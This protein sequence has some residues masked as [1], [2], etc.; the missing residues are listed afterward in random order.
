AEVPVALLAGAQHRQG[1]FGIRNSEF[2][3]REGQL[4]ADDRSDAGGTRRFVEPRRA[5][6]AVAIEERERGI[7]K[8]GGAIHPRFRK[9]RA[10]KKAEGGG[11]V[12]FDIGG[13]GENAEKSPQRT[14]R[15]SG[16]KTSGKP[17]LILLSS[18]SSVVERFFSQ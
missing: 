18:T 6:D 13:H 7:A 12:Q 3:I 1:P 15:T 10:L 4:R 16:V 9:R 2:G 8:I 11:R 5:V 17:S 14:R